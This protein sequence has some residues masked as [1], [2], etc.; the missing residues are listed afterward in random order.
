M[1]TCGLGRGTGCTWWWWSRAPDGPLQPLKWLLGRISQSR[2]A[3]GGQLL[4]QQLSRYSLVGPPGLPRPRPHEEGPAACLA[5]WVP[6]RA[7]AAEPCGEGPPP[8]PPA[9]AQWCE[10]TALGRPRLSGEGPPTLASQVPRP[11]VPL[12]VRS[13]RGRTGGPDFA[14]HAPPASPAARKWGQGAGQAET[15]PAR[16]TPPVPFPPPPPPTPS[17][18]AIGTWALPQP[19]LN[20]FV[21]T[22]RHNFST[23]W[24]NPRP[25]R[26]A[27]RA[28]RAP[29]LQQGS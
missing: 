17:R 3:A 14:E 27:P 25:R 4:R 5:A 19:Q 26:L 9:R 11:A 18:P 6:V 29:K 28:H 15:R 23:P 8:S 21:R 16:G 22:Y 2:R 12:A 1:C 10:L 20:R 7:V 24:T 13:P